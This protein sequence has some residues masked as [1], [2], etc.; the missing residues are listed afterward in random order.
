MYLKSIEIQGFKSF[1]NKTV[2]R[3]QNGITG[4][5]GPN[6]SGKSNVADAVRWV[7]GE[8]RVKELRGGS[9]QDVIFAGTQT[10]KPMGY[11]AVFITLDNSDH[12]LPVS[13]EEVTIGRRLYR[14]G[15]SEYLIN[16]SVCRL[17]DVQEVFYDTGIGREGYSIIGQ[18][19]I[20]KI[21]SG[22]PEERRELFD[23]AAGI[24]KYKKRKAEAVR[25][26]D[27]EH[28]NLLRVSDILSELDRQLVPMEHQ[29]KKARIY[30]ARRDELRVVEANLFM[31]ETEQLRKEE[32]QVREKLEAA[33]QE[34]AGVQ[35]EYDRAK[36][37]Y[38][39]LEEAS[40]GMDQNLEEC[41][42]KITDAKM[43]SQEMQGKIALL[44]E[45]ISS[46]KKSEEMLKGR[47]DQ[48]TAELERRAEDETVY[49][50]N[51]EDLAGQESELKESLEE[52]QDAQARAA[53]ECAQISG[54][55]E[56][57]K[58]ERIA[59]ISS[60][61]ELEAKIQRGAASLEQIGIR[62]SRLSQQLLALGS[63]EE[64]QQSAIS[65]Y[66][67]DRGRVDETISSLDAQS[68]AINEELGG[69]Q[70][71]LTRLNAELE[72]EQE[73]YHRE[74]SHLETLRNIAERYDGYGNS[75]RRVMEQ[76]DIEPGLVGVVAD[77]LTTEK[78][79]E[80]AVETALGGSIQN[81]VTEDEDTA[82]R[83]I[84]F[85]KTNRFGRCTFLPLTAMDRR[86]READKAVLR[87]PGVIGLASSLVRCDK[88][89]AG[90]AEHLL[91]RTWVTDDIDHAAALAKAFH[92]SL[93]I[94]TLEGE[95]LSP[96]GSMTGG[97][98]KNSSNLMGRRRE[99]EEAQQKVARREKKLE[100]LRAKIAEVRAKREEARTRLV[101]VS[102]QLQ[103]SYL[104]Q[105]T[106]RVRLNEAESLSIRTQS[107]RRQIEKEKAELE[108]QAAGLRAEAETLSGELKKMT[109]QEAML[110]RREEFDTK[111]LEKARAVEEEKM[112]ALEEAKLELAA[113][114]Q[115]RTFLESNLER[116]RAEAEG[117]R[118]EKE[119]VLAGQ[120]EGSRQAQE[121]EEEIEALYAAIN[122]AQA[123]AEAAQAEM[124]KIQAAR[125]ETDGKRRTFF[126]RR[127]ELS[128]RRS[129]LDK[130]CFR[131][132]GTLEKNEEKR[133]GLITSLWEEFELTPSDAAGLIRDDLGPRTQ[134]KKRAGELR[135]EIRGLGSVN[136]NAIEE[137][138]ELSERHTFLTGQQEDLQK[139]EDALHKIID[140]L[141]RGM[142]T[143]FEEQFALIRTEFDK[144][145]RQ[146]FGGGSG[147][148]ELVEGQDIL[149]AGIRIIASPP[150]KKLQNMMQ[151]SGG[152]KAL[153][154]IAL[155]FAIQNLKPSPFCLL[156]EIEAALDENNVD[157][158]AAYLHKLTKQTQFIIITH[159]RGTMSAADRL[160]GV[161]MQEKGVS[162]Q[163]SVDLIEQELDA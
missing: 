61:S 112:R 48:I 84:R 144:A 85:L 146:L 72:T 109:Q 26:L 163:V 76:K 13:Y 142:R 55:I 4:I 22:R 5:V 8:Q 2:F 12:S 87:H 160:Y 14:S 79:Y 38:D 156:D 82:K 64:E 56:E 67:S 37:E 122:E 81:I 66:E 68:A 147:T 96:G 7:L 41:R 138:K 51:L 63:E 47:L 99:I 43:Q 18:G 31:A 34:L 58:N 17:R 98:F 155:L 62:D 45:Q 97:A 19:Q 129:L 42:Q 6:G 93:R 120:G 161:T 10:R 25:R 141:D 126:A 125:E 59:L 57:E 78:K 83:M 103:R 131:L 3:F 86:T 128:E 118:K 91:G 9:M 140:E 20:E 124:E 148:L 130:E 139:A 154:A 1:A 152:E 46:A 40:R 132:S 134:L 74:A 49:S 88:K 127:E 32:E 115:Q 11:A 101:A 29:A 153:T 121:K 65:T 119:T 71:E 123:A 70:E 102:E 28:Q 116:V 157:R 27:N 75:I 73:Q 162:A 104:K 149:E 15:E 133:D 107:S 150:G 50:A 53:R 77:L 158:F 52:A 117:F 60:R 100:S 39:E 151:M 145:F 110:R 111:R 159:R 54:A 36:A 35:A 95:L 24:V 89:Y 92:Y 30:L 106:L 108:K 90:V 135:G 136:V 69:I 143:R 16:G 21:L 137:F 80:T 44:R 23:E 114:E 105:N 94:V 33:T 113:L